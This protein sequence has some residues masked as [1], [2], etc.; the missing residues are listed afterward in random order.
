MAETHKTLVHTWANQWNKLDWEEYGSIDNG[1]VKDL[2]QAYSSYPGCEGTPTGGCRCKCYDSYTT[3]IGAVLWSAKLKRYV[4]VVEN[5]KKAWSTSTKRHIDLLWQ[6]IPRDKTYISVP[7]HSSLHRAI[8]D[9][10]CAYVPTKA[11]DTNVIAANIISEAYKQLNTFWDVK[12]NGQQNNIGQQAVREQYILGV[13]SLV[14]FIAVFGYCGAITK[15]KLDKLNKLVLKIKEYT[16]K[17]KAAFNKAR[18]REYE[19][20]QAKDLYEANCESHKRITTYL[21]LVENNCPSVKL[22]KEKLK[23]NWQE[24]YITLCRVALNWDHTKSALYLM[25]YFVKTLLARFKA[26][27]RSGKVELPKSQDSI[28]MPLAGIPSKVPYPYFTNAHEEE[29]ATHTSYPTYFIMTKAGIL[30]SKQVFI[31]KP[32]DDKVYELINK[33]YNDENI[34]GEYIDNFQVIEQS[35]DSIIVGCHVFH[36]NHILT[37]GQVLN[38]KKPLDPEKEQL[39]INC[40]NEIQQSNLWQH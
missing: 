5:Y 15:A 30:T 40:L 35:A 33:V 23:D 28:L 10:Y 8:E 38:N 22:L 31:G 16:A 26:N 6:A 17:D 29:D 9:N 2:S 12:S 32:Q 21:D 39:I 14:E 34:I 19:I 13:Q 18:Q 25:Q 37:W 7:Y 11:W 4:I 1:I 36:I 24:L 20:R 3:H 27:K